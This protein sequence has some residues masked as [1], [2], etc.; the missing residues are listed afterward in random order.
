MAE[1]PAVE[2]AQF[3]VMSGSSVP[4]RLPSRGALG[5]GRC[6]RTSRLTTTVTIGTTRRSA[7]S[8]TSSSKSSYENGWESL[9]VP[10]WKAA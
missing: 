1:L 10:G 9:S 3:V 8:M 6:T 2:S 7:S 4:R 5:A